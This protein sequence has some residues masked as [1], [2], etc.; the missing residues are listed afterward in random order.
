MKIKKY[1]VTDMKE[2]MKRIKRDLGSDAIIIESRRVRRKGLRGFFMPPQLEIIAAVDLQKQQFPAGSAMMKNVIE[3]ERQ[4]TSMADE[5]KELRETVAE[6]STVA[7]IND[8]VDSAKKIITRKKS[9][10]YWRSY[11]EHHDLDPSL[12]EE[13]FSEAEAAASVPGRMSHTRMAEILRE[14][15]AT[16]ISF[17]SGFNCRTQVFIGPTGVGKTTTL[18]KLAARASLDRQEKVGLVTIDHYRVGAVEQ[19]R[20]YAEIMDLPMEVVMS[21]SDLFK[22]MLRLNQCDRIFVDTAGRSTGSSEQL[23]DLAP[24]IE[25]LLP[26]DIHLVISATTRCQDISYITERFKRLMYNR[27]V[28][29]KLDET[30]SYGAI[31]NSSY[32]SKM[33]LVYLTDGQR[34]PEDLK[35]ASDIDLAGILWK[36]G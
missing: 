4:M 31:L 1:L 17:A 13:I 7:S 28:L 14:K 34:V 3:K 36:A 16:K 35:L 21:P 20:S 30:K 10:A 25:M 26:A 11:L 32:F 5:L 33:P 24:Y 19:L 27:L 12:L 15:A 9:A 29:T 8:G 22:V 23:S 6:L 18:A 2:G